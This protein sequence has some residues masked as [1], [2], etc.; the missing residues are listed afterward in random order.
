MER[1]LLARYEGGC[2][3]PIGALATKKETVWKFRA[4]IGGVRSHR[5]LQDLVE[6]EDP[7][8]C[9]PRMFELLQKLG[10]AE[11]LQELHD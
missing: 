11:L 3:L 10:A 7:N 2:H 6:D 5:L 4:L 8:A 1:E 9:A